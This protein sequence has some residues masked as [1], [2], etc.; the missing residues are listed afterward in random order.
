MKTNDEGHDALYQRF[1]QQ[2]GRV[3]WDAAEQLATSI[4]SLNQVIRWPAFPKKGQVLELGCGAGNICLELAKYGFDVYGIDIAPTAIAWAR[5]KASLAGA[6]ASFSVG[7]VLD[8]KNFS[9]NS[10]D[11]VLDGHCL[12]CIIGNDRQHFLSNALRVLR[13][14]GT[15]LVCTMCNE[16]PKAWVDR[17][18]FDATTRCTMSADGYATRYIGWSN[19]VIGEVIAAG[20][21]V[22]QL[23]IEPANP[24]A[25][26]DLDELLLLARKP[27]G[28]AGVM[29]SHTSGEHFCLG[30]GGRS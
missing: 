17:G 20:F 28:L 4:A 11:V 5:E 15:L 7:N 24:D 30:A 8:L 6:G 29:A 13:P 9:G 18:H 22:V 19:D 1:R 25:A 10:F 16:V 3:G 2:P 27:A 23:M 26:E 21:D 14:G 12:H